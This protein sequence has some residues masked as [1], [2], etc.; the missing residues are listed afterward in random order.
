MTLSSRDYYN[1]ARQPLQQVEQ[2]RL[3]TPCPAGPSQGDCIEVVQTPYLQPPLMPSLPSRSPSPDVLGLPASTAPARLQEE[4]LG[5]K[6]KR[7]ITEAYTE[8]RYAG[9]PSLGYSQ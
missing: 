2:S 3:N 5:A 4:E 7:K 9:L 8:A 6:R 1:L